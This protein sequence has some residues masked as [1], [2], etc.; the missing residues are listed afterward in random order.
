MPGAA[1]KA[2]AIRI[3]FFGLPRHR[4]GIAEIDL[5]AATLGD[6]LCE[7][8]KR[9]PQLE[10][11]CLPDGTLSGGYLANLNGRQFVSDPKTPLTVG[12]CVLILSSD[13]GG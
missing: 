13:V 8:R 4:A 3:E 11:I 2:V 5:C 10:Q 6:A 1:A 7:A 9:L 12:D